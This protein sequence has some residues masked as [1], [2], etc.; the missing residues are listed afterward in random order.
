MA[1]IL[2]FGKYTRKSSFSES[3]WYEIKSVWREVKRLNL[4]VIFAII[5]IILF[6][7][8][9]FKISGEIL[10]YIN[11]ASTSKSELS[12]GLPSNCHL[13]VDFTGCPKK[14]LCQPTPVVVCDKTEKNNQ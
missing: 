8:F 2:S 7:I 14:E 12:S 1:E 13:A 3:T 5:T 9:A 4:F 10:Q 6:T 11:Y